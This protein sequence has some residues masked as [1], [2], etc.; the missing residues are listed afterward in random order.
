MF[1]QLTTSKIFKEIPRIIVEVCK[2]V[3]YFSDYFETSGLFETLPRNF[4]HISDHRHWRGVSPAENLSTDTAEGW[5]V[6]EKRSKILEKQSR[7]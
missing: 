6:A 1:R 5:V 3:I 2:H 7:N 4:W